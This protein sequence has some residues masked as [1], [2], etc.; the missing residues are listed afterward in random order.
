MTIAL[1][2]TGKTGSETAHL[3]EERGLAVSSFNRSRPPTLDGLRGA[4]VAVSFLPGDAFL[5]TIPVL[6]DSRLPVVSGSTGFDFPGGTAAF[7]KSLR[8]KGLTWI[9]ASNFSLGMHLV[10][11][12]LPILG[13]APDLLPDATFAIRETHHIHKKDAPSGTALSWKAWLGRPADIRSER[14]GDVVGDHELT[15]VSSTERITLRHEALSRRIFAEGAL[16]AAEWILNPVKTPGPGLHP[17]QQVVRHNLSTLQPN[18][19]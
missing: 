16:Q 15:L 18:R 7:D 13:W 1:L 14:T 11:E 10:R 4:D 8:E 12:I 19:P 3:A 2:G 9:H 5:A 6:I 17:F